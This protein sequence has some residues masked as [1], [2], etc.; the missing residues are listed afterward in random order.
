MDEQRVI[1]RQGLDRLVDVLRGD[2]YRVVGPTV[3]SCS[4]SSRRR[5]S[6]P[7]GG[8]SRPLPVITGCTAGRTARVF[9]H[10]AG[11]QSWKQVLHPAR[12]Q[13]WTSDAP[14]EYRA[15]EPDDVRYAPF[16]VHGCN[17]AAIAVLDRVLAR[18]A[19]PGSGYTRRRA[20][21][22][23]AAAHCTE[24]GGVFFSA[25]MARSRR[26]GEAAWRRRPVPVMLGPSGPGSSAPRDR[27]LVSPTEG[28]RCAPR[29][30]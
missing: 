20:G 13:L 12:E 4:P 9:A 28:C 14:G 24:P 25:S 2:G 22:F 8:V 23:V 21:M 16:G 29:T 27:T 30:S 1:D 5:R 26:P 17:L 11:P 6:C 15:P 19:Q 18:G 7:R 10:S 3:R